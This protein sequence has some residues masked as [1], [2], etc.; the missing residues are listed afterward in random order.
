MLQLVPIRSFEGDVDVFFATRNGTVKKTL[1][2]DFQNVNK[3]GIRAINVE[4]G[5]EIVA[6]RLVKPSDDV[7]MLTKDGRAMRFAATDVRRMGRTATG[8]R[9][10]RLREGD[11][12]VS[13]DVVDNEKTLFIATANGFGKRCSF[14]DFTRHNRGGQG[15]I[16]IKGA[17]RNGEV[18]AA[19]AVSD[20]ENVISITS[21]QQMVRSPVAQFNVQGRMAQ[22]V[23]LVRLSEGATLVSV[24]VCEGA[25]EEDL[26]TTNNEGENT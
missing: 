6:V 20:D 12:V 7:L 26:A 16:G 25:D 10:I 1:L 24:S 17:D 2:G 23:K 8:V 18:V 14:D 9:G 19:H 22:G 5:D 13:F 4:E 15:M 3:S 11:R 21:D